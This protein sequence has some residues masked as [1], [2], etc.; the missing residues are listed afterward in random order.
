MK[1]PTPKIAIYVEGGIVQ[2]VRSNIGDQLDV[3]I[4]D[5]DNEPNKADDRWEEL[6]D[7]LEF[8]NY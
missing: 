7:E 6:Q 2:A 3:E 5:C 8:G 1:T 4:V